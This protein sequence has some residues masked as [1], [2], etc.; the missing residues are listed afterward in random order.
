VIQDVRGRYASQG[1]WYPFRHESQDGYDSVEWAAALPYA[2]G[3]VGMFG[4]SYVGATQ[5]LAAIATPPHLAGIFPVITPSN[6][7]EGWVYQGGA[8]EQ[9][10]N[11]SW[12]TGLASDTLRRRVENSSDPRKWAKVLPLASY[13]LLDMGTTH[14]LAPYFNDWLAHPAYDD[15]WKAW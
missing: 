12:T 6:Y 7:H 3:K 5:L 14:G 1:D 4:G 11:E 9:W 15:Y 2:N 8:F 10:F 13:P